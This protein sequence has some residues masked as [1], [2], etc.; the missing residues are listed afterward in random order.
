MLKMSPNKNWSLG[1]LKELTKKFTMTT[2]VLLMTDELRERIVEVWQRLDQTVIDSA[3]RER[4]C[5]LR[6]Y[7]KA[8]GH[9]E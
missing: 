8:R 4:H 1:G 7:I 6:A 3:V 2:Q 5:R 9:F